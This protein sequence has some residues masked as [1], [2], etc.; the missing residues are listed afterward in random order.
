MITRG[1][2][3]LL[4]AYFVSITASY[5]F[6]EAPPAAQPCLDVTVFV[7]T[8][9]PHCLAA[10]EFLGDLQSRDARLQVV[11]LEINRDQKAKEKFIAFNRKNAIE[12]PGVPTFSICGQTIIG[13]EPRRVENAIYHARTPEPDETAVELPL[14]GK[15]ELVEV[16]LPLFTVALGLIDGF[17]PCAMWVLLFLLSILVHVKSRRRIALIA[18]T[19]VLISGLVYFAFMA[20][21]LNAFLFL[22]YSRLIQVIIGIVAI[23]IGLIHLKDFFALHQGISLS[24]SESAKPAIYHRVRQ[25]VRSEKTVVALL[26]VTLLAILVNFLELLCTAGLPALYTQILSQHELSSAGYY[27]YLALYNLAY[28]VDDGL[29]VAVAVITLGPHRLQEKQGRWLKLISGTIVF[30]LG[31][32]LIAAPERLSF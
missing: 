7:T 21:W 4:V 30:I 26:G 2:F 29:M 24:I 12:R 9:C 25:V 27:A 20:A 23:F 16:G 15:I 6:A 8:T 14:L 10:G 13:F 1:I 18:T 19:F 5:A 11:M 28:I 17:N 22:G 32:L 3:C 31:V